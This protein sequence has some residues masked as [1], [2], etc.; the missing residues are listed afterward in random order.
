MKV[1]LCST[2]IDLIEHRPAAQTPLSCGR[3]AGGEVL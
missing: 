2:Y 1:F 3:G